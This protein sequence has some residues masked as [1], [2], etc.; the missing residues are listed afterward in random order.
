MKNA[1]RTTVVLGL[2]ICLATQL[3]GC[4]TGG[5]GS[6]TDVIDGGTGTTTQVRSSASVEVLTP[7]AD[8]SIIGGTQVEV[9]WRAFATTQFAVLDVIIDEDQIPDNDNEIVARANGPLSE[10]TALVDT[11]LL[12][13]GA[14]FVG[15]RIEEVG[16]IV[17]FGYAPGQIIIDQRP[18]LSFTSPRGNF[19]YD[20]TRLI[21]PRFDVAWTLSDPDSVNTVEIFLDPDEVVNGNEVLLFRSSSQTGD[22]FSFDLPTDAFEAG[23]YRILALVSDG[24]NFTPFY[25]PGSILLRGRLAGPVDLRDL[26]LGTSEVEGCVFEGFNPHDNAGSTVASIGDIDGDGFGD[27]MILSQF[28]KPRYDT[29]EQRT[30]IGEAYLVYGRAQRFVGVNNLN[31]TGALFRGVVYAGVE[32]TGDPVRPTRG[33]TSFTVLSDWDADGVREMAFGLPFTDSETYSEHPMDS[34]GAFRTGAVIVVAGRTLR[35][36]LGFPGAEVE[37]LSSF[38]TQVFQACPTTAAGCPEGF[39][40]PH[41]PSTAGGFTLFHRHR[42]CETIA[43]NLVNWGCRIWTND[44][45]DQCGDSLSAYEF[46]SLII[47]VPNRDPNVCTTLGESRKGAGVVSV[48]YGGSSLWNRN[49][50][51]LPHDG[52]YHYVLDDRRGEIFSFPDPEGEGDIIDFGFVEGSPGYWVDP[53]DGP[54]CTRLIF[55]PTPHWERTTRIYG[56]FEG[57]AIGNVEGAGDLNGDGL[58]D[59]LIGSP[60]SE[61][62]AGASFIILGRLRDLVMSGELDLEELG[63]PMI[64][65][66][67]TQQ[68][69]Y[70]GI[71]VVGSPGDRLGQ[72][73]SRAGDFNGDGFADVI[74]GSPLVNSRRG[75]AAIFFG[76]RTIINL[77]EAEIPFDEI[78]SRGLGVIFEGELEGDLAG[79]RVSSAGDVDGDGNTDVLIAAPD[80]SIRLD[81]D[82]DGTLEIDRTQCGVVYLVYGSPDL[83]GTISLSEIGTSKLPGAV[84]IGRRSGDHLGAGLGDQGD[85]SRSISMAGDVDGDG[86]GDLLLGS[87]RASPRDRAAAGEVYLIYGVGD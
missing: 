34:E 76:D 87:V 53:G 80:R 70:D 16:E 17:A 28:G 79:A 46:D 1:M 83:K 37:R 59:I 25:A 64:A 44:F 47:S 9:N 75:G 77:T 67:P 11:T 43:D 60:L 65:S 29:N 32:E 35:Q 62:G 63:L 12:A 2:G 57:A 4:P 24:Q 45:G 36:D 54:P 68:R 10:S 86:I 20:R 81:I 5:T 13:R 55:E 74:I 73:Q 27:M 42:F 52:P 48:F 15:V 51:S 30:G 38:G 31:S 39:Y 69:I 72:A 8:L 19:R 84:F 66:D 14:Y 7:A 58:R 33:I 22:S 56:G 6:G 82:L 26:D 49:N 18:D 40:G 85:R 41:A 50:D 23:T 61:D 21:A 71:R 78:A 3:G